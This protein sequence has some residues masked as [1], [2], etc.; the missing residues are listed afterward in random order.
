MVEVRW[1]WRV[2]RAREAVASSSD[3][4]IMRTR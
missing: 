4:K 3:V 1:P 2:S